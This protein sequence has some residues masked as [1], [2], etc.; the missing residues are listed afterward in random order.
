MVPPRSIRL[1][2]AMLL[3]L[4]ASLLSLGLP[5]C[6]RK[7][8]ITGPINERPTVAITAS[9]TSGPSP[10]TVT[11]T[12]VAADPDGSIASYS[13]TFSDSGHVHGNVDHVDHTFVTQGDYL[14]TL[15]ATDNQGAYAEAS[16]IIR[17]GGADQAPIVDAGIGQVNLDPGATVALLGSVTEPERQPYTV[18]WTQ[19]SGPVVT[20]S[21][22]TV[23]N[24]TFVSVGSSSDS[25]TFRLS[26]TDNGTPPNTGSGNVTINTRVTWSNTTQAIFS[27]R[28]VS[29]HYTSSGLPAW[30]SYTETSAYF[31][32]I[33]NRVSLGG[34]MRGY[35]LTSPVNQPNVLINWIDNGGP[36]S[37]P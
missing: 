4:G 20:L 21:D 15:R 5:A 30:Q 28:C 16:E 35:L 34:N 32:S 7:H 3:M 27:A 24:P 6:S 12:G 33:K 2:P 29:C 10:L 17:V 25:Y 9:A 18:A 31:A 11:F 8:N 14:V 26:A 13:W 37:N 36:Q 1:L 23:L 19:I 22:P